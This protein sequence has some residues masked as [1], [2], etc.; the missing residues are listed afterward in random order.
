MRRPQNTSKVILFGHDEAI[1]KQNQFTPRAWVMG[2]GTAILT[3]K[4][5]GA[6]VMYSL[7]VSRATGAGFGAFWNDKMK[8]LGQHYFDRE[9]AIAVHG[10]SLKDPLLTDPANRKFS[11][12][13][14]NGWWTGNHV[15]VQI[16]DFL[17]IFFEVFENERPL[18]LFD[19]ST[20]HSKGRVNGLN[21]N[22][23][24]KNYGGKQHKLHPNVITAN[25]LGPYSP[26]LRPGDTQR[27]TFEGGDEGPFYLDIRTRAAKKYDFTGK[28]KKPKPLTISEL[29]EELIEKGIN[30]GKRKKPEL[31]EIS[32]TS[33]HHIRSRT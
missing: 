4:T 31:V 21:V 13:G 1:M 2:D 11:Y 18:L 10:K 7:F 15:I 12:G 25:C 8:R 33:W 14:A 24:N 9:A 5:E 23:M 22:N 29:T 16:E 27:F 28:N 20:G 30:V 26:K 6:G 3:P 19:N 32:Y 17:D